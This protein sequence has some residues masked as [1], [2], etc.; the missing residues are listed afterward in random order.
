MN[1]ALIYLDNA[2]A[3]PS[4]PCLLEYFK[5][6]SL[7]S[8]VNQEAAHQAASALR[9][10]LEAAACE[11]GKLLSGSS[12]CGVC[13]TSSGTEGLCSAVSLPCF[14]HGN[15]V[16]SKV[17]HPALEE[18]LR[19]VAGNSRTEL[20]YVRIRADGQIDLDHFSSLLDEKTTLVALHHVQAETGALQD[21]L[22]LRRAID[23][24]APN[25]QFLAD[26]MQSA[27]KMPLPW[28]SARLDFAFV[29]GRKMGGPPL[30][31]ILF[32]DDPRG[33]K[34][35]FFAARR[36]RDHLSSRPDPASVLTLC[37]SLRQAESAIVSR[38][39][40]VLR[41]NAFLRDR[42]QS[43]SGFGGHRI[44]PTLPAD[45]SSPYILHF[46]VDACQGAVLVR[47]LGEKGIALGAG[48]ACAAES[49]KPSAALQAMGWRKE[50][51]YSGLRAS[52]W[53][54]LTEQKL[55]T[56][57]ERLREALELY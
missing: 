48:S 21:L 36:K 6:E 49:N 2:A 22:A 52:F 37:E 19:R 15:I 11:F 28:E 7:R 3:T 42:L 56:F 53:E 39:T 40:A 1:S 10:E 55:E 29:A 14:A 12:T 33:T 27:G 31:A 35:E 50:D 24:S 20:R 30:G 47:L 45:L 8:Y 43:L 41:M 32:R 46:S 18:A 5:K 13:W 4:T 51:A 25:A 38:S 17:E 26:T 34:R 23:R 54:E 9:E 44:L 16:S 57:M